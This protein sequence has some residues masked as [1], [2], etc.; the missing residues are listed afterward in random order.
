MLK[1]IV[2]RRYAQ[3]F[4]A[5][6]ASVGLSATL[7]AQPIK[8]SGNLVTGGEVYT[9]AYSPDGLYGVFIANKDTA[10]KL[11]LY[12]V[13]LSNGVTTKLSGALVT[14]GSVFDLRISADSSRVVF[15]ADKDTVGIF[16][17]Y[18]TPI[19]SGA[20]IKISG[21]LVAGGT[22]DFFS[23]NFQ[24]SPDSTRVV[25]VATKD[26]INRAEL[27]S[28]PIATNSSEPIKISGAIVAG[29]D[30][31]NFLI[32]PDSARVVFLADKDTNDVIELYTTPIAS[33]API[34]ISGPLVL[35]GSAGSF[36]ISPD[37]AR[38]VFRADKDT[39]GV[40]EL[41]STP[42]ASSAPIKISGTLVAGGSTNY[43]GSFKISPDSARVVF[44][45]DK[46][47]DDVLELYSTPIATNSSEP[48][49]I[50]GTLAAN[51]DVNSF[52]ISPDS[53]RVVFDADKDTNG[54]Q[55]LY[56][57]PIA[58]SAPIKISGGLVTGGEVIDYRISPDSARVV[59]LAD[60]DINDVQ[61]LYSTPIAS[62]APIKISGPLVTGGNVA[63]GAFL[64]SPDSTRVVFLSDKDTD[65]VRE[66]YS[67]PIA[68]NSS[69]PIKISGLLVSG[70]E[71]DGGFRISPDSARVMFSA[72][73]DT[74]DVFELYLVQIGG[75]ALALDFD[76]DDRVLP[77]TDA[78]LLA[79]YKAG[80][81]GAAL[82]ANALGVNATATNANVI[83][84]RIRAALGAGLPF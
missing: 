17:L 27:Y 66:L 83:R 46:D 60:K 78:L 11:E 36:Q 54:V 77:E 82:T 40:D 18:S 25:F 1:S 43:F 9:F 65:E 13:R 68:T 10:G 4:C 61:E 16:E 51:R 79:R 34:K 74:N 2:L 80:F 67:T 29:G 7:S 75:T 35:G 56:S 57:T 39:D 32:S 69:A 19:A 45:A 55:E 76:G 37:S 64:I 28:A 50:S 41:Y 21:T 48:I 72:D 23:S 12:S 24:I 26:D 53:A 44:V 6:I 47:T 8:I 33:N 81:R 59:F 49:K 42:I 3:L 30:V 63:F 5:I 70:G 52:L 58:S 15:L 31:F 20:P 62:G 84:S 14:G 73:K 71:V 22:V 38:V